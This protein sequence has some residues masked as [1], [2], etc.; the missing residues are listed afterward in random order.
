MALAAIPAAAV[1]Q[2]GRETAQAA[3][4]KFPGR[5][6]LQTT[7]RLGPEHERGV[8]ALD[9]NDGTWRKVIN[10]SMDAQRASVSPDGTRLAVGRY[11]PQ[12]VDPGLWIYTTS[13]EDGPVRISE[14][15]GYP[16]WAPD[17]KSV[18]LTVIIARGQHEHWRIDADGSRE[19]RLP[20]PETDQ[21]LDWSPEG[22]WLL[23]ARG[24]YRGTHLSLVHPDG[25]GERT[26]LSSAEATSA[27]VNGLR[28]RLS[29][30]GV[31]AILDRYDTER[32]DT[33]EIRMDK[34]VG[35]SLFLLD[36]KGATPRR[37]LER[38]RD[39]TTHSVCWSPDGRMLAVVGS[40]RDDGRLI[41]Y[42]VDLVDLDGH[43]LGTI[44]VPE[45]VKY[46]GELI[47]WR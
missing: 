41:R 36:A 38:G 37:F 17:G 13:G 9:P 18:L 3:R 24:N 15:R 42:H 35:S 27:R 2:E 4:P 43:L 32:I 45:P 47:D 30:D 19:E 21:V 39:E 34:V 7:Y 14:R 20:I 33:D 26:L 8:I 25:S 40:Q 23:T 1:A 5:I 6:F 16:C 28:A 29:P 31:H 12:D 22:P 10:G 44:P 11:S 46:F